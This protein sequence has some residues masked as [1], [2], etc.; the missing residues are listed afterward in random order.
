MAAYPL[1]K[2]KFV[3]K[4]FIN[5][6]YVITMFLGGGLIPTYLL[7]DKLNLLNTIWAMLLPGAINVWNIMLAKTYFKS[8]PKELEKLHL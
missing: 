2:D 5:T 3:G 6:L 1:S 7:M 8:L 4:K